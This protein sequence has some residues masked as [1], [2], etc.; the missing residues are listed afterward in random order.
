M[1]IIITLIISKLI[2][3]LINNFISILMK[4]N[5]RET[6]IL[7]QDFDN[8]LSAVDDPISVIN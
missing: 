5:I 2:P 4:N 8:I 6:H 1:I 7:D 3:E